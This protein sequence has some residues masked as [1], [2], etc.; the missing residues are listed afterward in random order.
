MFEIPYSSSIVCA[1]PHASDHTVKNPTATRRACFLP[2]ISLIL[3][4]IIIKPVGD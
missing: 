2:K 3:V 4:N 1:T